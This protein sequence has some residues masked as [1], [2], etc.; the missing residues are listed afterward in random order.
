VT[1]RTVQSPTELG[2]LL[3]AA[4][5]YEVF[6]HD[7]APLGA[8]ERIRYERQVSRPDEIVVCGRWFFRRRR[9]TFPFEAIASVSVPKSSVVLHP[10]AA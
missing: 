9:R 5:G 2:R 8:L 1:E 4:R 6:S 7:G 3:A 10:G